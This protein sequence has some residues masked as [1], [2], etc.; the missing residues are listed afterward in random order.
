MLILK[1][2]GGVM[3]IEI[4][5]VQK[6]DQG[7][8]VRVEAL[9]GHHLDFVFVRGKDGKIH[10]ILSSHIEYPAIKARLWRRVCGVF[11]PKAK[12]KSKSQTTFNF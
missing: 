1:H 11:S 8:V 10:E 9:V 5:K 12:E 3:H 4:T 7:K 2:Q 6:D